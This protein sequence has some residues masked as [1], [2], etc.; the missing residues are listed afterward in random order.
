[1]GAEF[2]RP[3]LLSIFIAEATDGITKLWTALHPRDASIPSAEAVQPHYVVAHTIKGAASMY[4]FTGVVSLADT[5][6][7]VLEQATRVPEAE[8]PDVLAMLRDTVGTLRAQVEAIGRQ[9]AEDQVAVEAWKARYSRMQPAS[10][11]SPAD[12][13]PDESLS[14]SYLNPDL[15]PEVIS[16]FAPEAQ[17]YVEAIEASLLR[18]EK[19]PQD[20]DTIQ[21]LFRSAHTLKG[22]AY[23]V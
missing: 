21:Q 7:T 3:A 20:P 8:W 4:G 5:L 19:N 11:T 1:M 16:Y 14:D 10:P 12:S 18:L 17:E 22:S 15:D 23:T 13:S 6:E 2:D 9:G